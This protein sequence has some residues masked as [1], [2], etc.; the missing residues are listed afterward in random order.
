MKS[1]ATFAALAV[2]FAALFAGC[3]SGPEKLKLGGKPRVDMPL[4]RGSS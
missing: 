2:A 4:P 3:D 1:A